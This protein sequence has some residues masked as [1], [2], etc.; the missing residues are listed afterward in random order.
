M[1]HNVITGIKTIL[2][3]INKI[4]KNYIPFN[5]ELKDRIIRYVDVVT[6]TALPE[7]NA[8]VFTAF[9]SATLTLAD[10][11]GNSYVG[12]SVPLDRYNPTKN[13][14]D[15]IAIDK[16]ISFQNSYI[17][18]AGV[19]AI[20]PSFAVVVVYYDAP[21]FAQINTTNDLAVESFEVKVTSASFKNLL[22][23]NRTLVGKRFKQIAIPTG[24][25]LTPS[26]QQCG[27]DVAVEGAYITLVKDNYLI[28]DN[29]PLMLFKEPYYLRSLN[30][31]NITFDFINSYITVGGKD[32]NEAA[33]ALVGKS[34][35]FNILYENN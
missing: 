12:Y 1:E 29:A 16:K 24:V 17:E 28:F 14:G 33:N 35:F 11:N 9:A 30:F 27:N 18:V 21:E 13:L 6:P 32:E 5:E 8:N 15:R 7:S 3:P 20:T 34:V 2:V 31:R 22:P 26:Y 4:G 25:T 23:D 19:G 10:F